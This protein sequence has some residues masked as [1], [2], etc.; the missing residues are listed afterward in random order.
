MSKF[1]EW[2]IAQN[3]ALAGPSVRRLP[4]VGEGKACI[5][6]QMMFC[7]EVV[8]LKPPQPRRQYARVSRAYQNTIHS[9][10]SGRPNGLAPWDYEDPDTLRQEIIGF[11]E[12]ER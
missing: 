11:P 2:I 10:L 5:D 3:G 12:G 4:F 9:N 6:Q 8:Q 7:E 1:V